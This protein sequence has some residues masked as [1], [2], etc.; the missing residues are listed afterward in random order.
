MPLTMN[1]QNAEPVFLDLSNAISVKKN[2]IL[3]GKDRGR[4]ARVS[5]N[6]EELYENHDLVVIVVPENVIGI[7]SSFING[8]LSGVVER[9]GGFDAFFPRLVVD[10]SPKIVEG[11]IRGLRQGN[12]PPL[13]VGS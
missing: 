9:L 3:T 13:K 10:A 8:L 7:S 4:A 12:L 6:V 2:T 11:I 1:T 5:L